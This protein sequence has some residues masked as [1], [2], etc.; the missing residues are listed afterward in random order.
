ML[1]PKVIKEIMYT[2]PSL[3]LLSA[4]AIKISRPRKPLGDVKS[5]DRGDCE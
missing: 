2:K 1:F 3:H 4:V 5:G